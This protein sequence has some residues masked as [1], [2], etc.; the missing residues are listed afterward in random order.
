M[1]SDAPVVLVI[2][3]AV[4]DCGIIWTGLARV[5]MSLATQDHVDDEVN[6][7]LNPVRAAALE[8]R[9]ATPITT[10]AVAPVAVFPQATAPLVAPH[11]YSS[12]LV[13]HRSSL[14]C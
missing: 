5:V 12:R 3:A 14:A 2:V 6:A 1:T 10:C 4:P 9:V 13:R 7:G 8:A 11:E